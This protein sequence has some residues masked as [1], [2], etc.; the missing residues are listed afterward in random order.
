MYTESVMKN[1]DSNTAATK[2]SESMFKN[3][4][5]VI[6]TDNANREHS[7]TV[8]HTFKHEGETVYDITTDDGRNKWSCADQIR[9]AN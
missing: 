4:Q 1:K 9:T 6:F 3:G 8:G 5:R 7:A 2:A